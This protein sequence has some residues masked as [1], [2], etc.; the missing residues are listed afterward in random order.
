M[1]LFCV[2]CETQGKRVFNVVSDLQVTHSWP[3]AVWALIL[4]TEINS[5]KHLGFYEFVVEDRKSVV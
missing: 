3:L 4:K 5:S 1:F 2:I